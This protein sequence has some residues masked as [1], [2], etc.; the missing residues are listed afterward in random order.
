MTVDLVGSIGGYAA[1]RYS[2][3]N[4]LVMLSLNTLITASFEQMKTLVP[5]DVGYDNTA[6][7]RTA[8]KTVSNKGRFLK[9]LHLLYF[10]NERII[11][12]I[13]NYVL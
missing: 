1:R 9:K 13:D 2:V 7:T 6:T 12:F 11:R 10:G 8:D 5:L 3:G 4:Y